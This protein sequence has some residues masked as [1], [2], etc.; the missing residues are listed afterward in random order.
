MERGRR[1]GRRIGLWDH[2]SCRAPQPARRLL[3]GEP[4]KPVLWF[5]PSLKTWDV[6]NGSY[7]SWSESQSP[8][9]TNMH[10]WGQRVNASAPTA[11]ATWPF[12]CRF[13]CSG[14][15]WGEGPHQHRGGHVGLATVYWFVLGSFRDALTDTRRNN[16]LNQQPGH[17]LAR[18]VDMQN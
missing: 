7:K 6:G 13:V 15:Q 3:L 16:V 5:S 17:P 9:T 18:E 1:R 2:G 8:G 4:G 12:L 14:L 11:R 10:V